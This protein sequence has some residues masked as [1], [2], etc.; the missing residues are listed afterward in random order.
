MD[1]NESQKRTM[2]LIEHDVWRKAKMYVAEFGGTIQDLVSAAVDED[3][4]KRR[5]EERS[6]RKEAA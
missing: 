2:V 3:I 5:K 1:T 6:K 4:R